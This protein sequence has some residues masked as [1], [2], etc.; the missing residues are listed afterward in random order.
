M[1]AHARAYETANFD[2]YSRKIG[3]SSAAVNAETNGRISD[4]LKEQQEPGCSE[5]QLLDDMSAVLASSWIS[6]LETW[7]SEAD[8]PKCE[9]KLKNSVYREF[10]YKDS[11]I[12]RTVGVEPVISINGV[13][14][15]IDK[16][17]HFMTEGLLY[18]RK[19]IEGAPLVDHRVRDPGVIANLLSKIQNLNPWA[20]PAKQAPPAPRRQVNYRELVAIGTHEENTTYG[21]ATT[22]IKSYGDMDADYQGYMFWSQLTHGPNPYLVCKNGRWSQRRQFKWEEY[23]NAGFDESI[24]CNSY[25]TQTMDQSVD[26][27][28]SALRRAEGNH[29]N[30]VCPFSTQ[31]CTELVRTIRP[32]EVANAILSPRC[33]NAA[34]QP[35]AQPVQ[36]T[37]RAKARQ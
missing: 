21:L 6:N 34:A 17:G 23:V 22:G 31:A 12:L 15:G 10:T 28:S 11:P 18:Y 32:P 19:S 3:D 35:G 20:T 16:L 2:C 1:S 33:R 8:I 30:L 14:L 4:Y 13:H 25:K 9:I 5:E 37:H 26:R 29:T 7:A 27:L 36:T 24:N